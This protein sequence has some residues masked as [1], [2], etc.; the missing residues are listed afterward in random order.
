MSLEF[1]ISSKYVSYIHQKTNS[2]IM[3]LIT[4]SLFQ[5]HFR[6]FRMKKSIVSAEIKLSY[7]LGGSRRLGVRCSPMTS[8]MKWRKMTRRAN[9]LGPLRKRPVAILLLHTIKPA[10]APSALI[11]VAGTRAAPHVVQ[12]KNKVCNHEEFHV[13][14]CIMFKTI[15]SINIT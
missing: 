3:T 9:I 10:R 4:M 2:K 1:C 6:H 5:K 8:H 14:T 13:Y 12:L 15:F 7:C 11:P